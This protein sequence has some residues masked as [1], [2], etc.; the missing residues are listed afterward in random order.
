MKNSLQAILDSAGQRLL[1]DAGSDGFAVIKS[2]RIFTQ[3]GQ[4]TLEA[5]P[6]FEESKV[7]FTFLVY[8]YLR[9]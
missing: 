8:L 9:S 7:V 4:T 1:F 6:L 3:E 5:L 2:R